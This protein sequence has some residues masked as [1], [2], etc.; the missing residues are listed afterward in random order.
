MHWKIIL[1]WRHMQGSDSKNTS[2]AFWPATCNGV[3]NTSRNRNN[4]SWCRFF[5]NSTCR[6][7]SQWHWPCRKYLWSWK[8]SLCNDYYSFL[9]LVYVI[10]LVEIEVN[11][12]V[13]YWQPSNLFWSSILPISNSCGT[14]NGQTRIR[15]FLNGHLV[16]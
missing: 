15:D 9:V 12:F 2:T 7:L 1:L 8:P 11:I 6:V 3:T 5:W 13:R 14:R 10:V 4:T 16:S